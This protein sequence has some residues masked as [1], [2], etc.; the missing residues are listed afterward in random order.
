MHL[1][2]AVD[3]DGEILDVLVQPRRDKT[4]A[5]KLMRKLFKKQGYAPNVLVTDKPP[6]YGAARR[7]PKM[8]A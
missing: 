2:R 6:S 4:A 7:E 3:A 8:Q 5:M 1:W